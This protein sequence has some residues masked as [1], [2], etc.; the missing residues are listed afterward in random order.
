MKASTQDF[1][2]LLK[3]ASEYDTRKTQSSYSGHL[4]IYNE[5]QGKKLRLKSREEIQKWRETN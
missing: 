5:F 4:K 3:W 2:L 1:K